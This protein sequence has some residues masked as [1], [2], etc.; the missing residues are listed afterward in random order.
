MATTEQVKGA[1]ADGL[2]AV[3]A[4]CD[5]YWEGVAA[6]AGKCASTD[7][8]GGPYSGDTYHE[9]KGPLTDFTKLCLVCG[10]KPRYAVRVGTSARVLACCEKHLVLVRRWQ[11][12]RDRL[13]QLHLP[14]APKEGAR[15]P[16]LMDRIAEAEAYF[17]EEDIRKGVVRPEGE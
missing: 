9:Y 7:G 1:L 15:R 16:S 8:C 6:G 17:R 12:A 13:V 11:Q 2:C 14:D 5:R 3:C 10:E 4:M